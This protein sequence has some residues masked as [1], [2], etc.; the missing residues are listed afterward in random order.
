MLGML[1]RPITTKD[2]D[3]LAAQ[4]TE[5]Q[6]ETQRLRF[7]DRY[8][9]VTLLAFTDDQQCLLGV[10]QYVRS[11]ADPRTAEVALVV[12]QTEIW[13]RAGRLLAESLT[14]V[15][16]RNGIARFCAGSTLPDH[17]FATDL[18]A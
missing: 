6:P 3:L 9:N 5:L 4:W 17:S 2:Q 10:A 11:L 14:E 12:A 13:E 15:A 1:V 16:R 7:D 18:A 8:A